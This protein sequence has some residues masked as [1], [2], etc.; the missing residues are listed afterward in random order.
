M[1]D[2]AMEWSSFNVARILPGEAESQDKSTDVLM[3]EDM[4]G[5]PSD[6][7]LGKA[8][9]MVMTSA[10]KQGRVP[11]EAIHIFQ[12]LFISAGTVCRSVAELALHEH[13]AHRWEFMPWSAQYMRRFCALSLVARMEHLLDQVAHIAANDKY[14]NIFR[15]LSN[16]A[17]KPTHAAKWNSTWERWRGLYAMTPSH[18]EFRA[19]VKRFAEIDD[20]ERTRKNEWESILRK[21]ESDSHREIF[22][23]YK[24]SLLGNLEHAMLE[25]D[26][27]TY[28]DVNK[29]PKGHPPPPPKH[30]QHGN[31]SASSRRSARS[32]GRSLRLSHLH[33]SID[34]P[35]LSCL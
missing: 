3:T 21:M 19:V 1:R 15:W 34:V 11:R 24:P 9:D 31:Q 17:D 27:R 8:K 32:D 29:E 13:A 2:R 12:K 33:G 28:I 10:D 18:L 23:G 22:I 25:W 5:V 20:H 16:Q 35:A 7:Q 6:W 4:Y 26:N 30:D 14:A